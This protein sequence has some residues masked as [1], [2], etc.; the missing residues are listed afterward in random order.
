VKPSKKRPPLP[1]EEDDFG[2]LL[3]EGGDPVDSMEED[4]ELGAY[5]EDEMGDL[6]EEDPLMVG[7][8]L[9]IDPE[10]AGLMD[11]LG[12][13]EPDQQQAFVDLVK[14]LMGPPPMAA[15]DPLAGSEMDMF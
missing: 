6:G 7:D 4:D 9:G 11:R 13:T 2:L 14:L 12:F 1:P 15:E 10:A 3:E 8:D 5:A